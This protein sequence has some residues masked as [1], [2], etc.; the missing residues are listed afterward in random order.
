MWR[1]H[2]L[3][4]HWHD[5]DPRGCCSQDPLYE[6]LIFDRFEITIAA[7]TITATSTAT[8]APTATAATITTCTITTTT[9]AVFD[10]QR[11]FHPFQSTPDAIILKYNYYKLLYEKLIASESLCPH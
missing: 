2:H 1:K 6:K 7:T 4:K 11:S 5:N 8:P 9:A 3:Q 10:H